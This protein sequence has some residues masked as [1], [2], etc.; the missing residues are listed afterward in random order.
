MI[1]VV[2][3]SAELLAITPA[4]DKLIEMAGRV[5]YKSEDK[6]TKDSSEKFIKMILK[7]GH[8]SVIE[9]SSA[10]IKVV[11][12][13]GISHE[14]VRHR[15]ASYSQES[16]RYCNYGDDGITVIAP[17]GIGVK[18]GEYDD[19][20]IYNFA[21][22]TPER[23]WLE[24]ALFANTSYLEMLDA[25]CKPEIA[26]SVLPTC[27]KT[28]I[29]ITYNFRQWRHFF[30]QRTSNKAHPD[31]QKVAVACYKILKNEAPAIFGEL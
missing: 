2:K 17:D 4:S 18:E 27:L 9:H 23:I 13:R 5:C 28:E 25:G 14:I 15:I 26:R 12:D 6:I 3:T 11:C 22:D 24:A 29:V 20:S 1:R 10:T 19:D 16:T 8:E 31:A 30:R 7:R 21:V